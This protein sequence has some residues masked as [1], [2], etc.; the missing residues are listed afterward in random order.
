[1]HVPWK[2]VSSRVASLQHDQSDTGPRTVA[3]RVVCMADGGVK[4]CGS[5][6]DVA[7]GGGACTEDEGDFRQGK[8]RVEVAWVWLAMPD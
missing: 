3:Y 5:V 6:V 1:M 8:A 2:Q 7:G 4:L